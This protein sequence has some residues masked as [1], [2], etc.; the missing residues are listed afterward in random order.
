MM[1]QF[2]LVDTLPDE[3]KVYIN[4]RYQVIVRADQEG[5]EWLSI[6]RKD[7]QVI[8]DWRELQEIKNQICGAE[9]EALELY[10]AE[11]R[12]VDS[13]NQFHLWVM[14]KGEMF[15]FGYGKRLVVKGHETDS[16]QREFENEPS[17]AITLDEYKEMARQRK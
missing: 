1:K 13:S 7:R 10:P 5:W 4:D 14:P 3:A 16:S 8:H 12:L 11:S 17:D 2:E 15:P 6:K 9:R